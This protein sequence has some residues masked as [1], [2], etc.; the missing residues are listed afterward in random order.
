MICAEENYVRM[1][2]CNSSIEQNVSDLISMCIRQEAGLN[3]VSISALNDVRISAADFPMFCTLLYRDDFHP[4][5]LNFKQSRWYSIGSPRFTSCYVLN[6]KFAIECKIGNDIL[7]IAIPFYYLI[8][9]SGCVYNL[10]QFLDRLTLALNLNHECIMLQ[11]VRDNVLSFASILRKYPTLFRPLN[12]D[13][14]FHLLDNFGSFL[15]F[16]SPSFLFS[17]MILCGVKCFE[18]TRNWESAGGCQLS[19]CPSEEL[20]PKV[21]S[22]QFSL[23]VPSK[24]EFELLLECFSSDYDSSEIPPDVLMSCAVI[25]KDGGNILMVKR[26]LRT[27]RS[28]S[29]TVNLTLASDLYFVDVRLE[30]HTSLFEYFLLLLLLFFTIYI[31]FRGHYL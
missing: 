14:Y 15:T 12:R 18:L 20:F 1:H 10:S 7:Y 25:A 21:H 24:T 13:F 2:F 30:V 22:G 4:H 27:L 19:W 17:N 8:L 16:I 5:E 29:Q 9:V 26:S 6:R 11:G 31:Y 3:I 28:L 23:I